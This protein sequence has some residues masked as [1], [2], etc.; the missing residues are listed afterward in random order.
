MGENQYILHLPTRDMP[1]LI[2]PRRINKHGEKTFDGT[3]TDFF[4]RV[5]L[6]HEGGSEGE[7]HR[8]RIGITRGPRSRWVT[9]IEKVFHPKNHPNVQSVSFSVKK[10][11][12]H[13]RKPQE[14]FQLITRIRRINFKRKLGLRFP[15]TIRLV[16]HDDGSYSILTSPLSVVNPYELNSKEEDRFNADIDRQ[17]TILGKMGVRILKD[18]FFC[19]RNPN[20]N[21]IEAIIAD[22]G[23]ISL[24][25]YRPSEKR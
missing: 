16:K 8:V 15:R 18:S 24:E 21:E 1:T 11:N 7:V 19:C 22:F 12:P 9:L 20:T 14:Q 25:R 2:R 6:V 5:G 10:N 13:L 23:T 4:Q 17:S 3:K